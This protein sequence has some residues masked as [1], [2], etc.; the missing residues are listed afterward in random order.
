MI[1]TYLVLSRVTPTHRPGSKGYRKYYRHR[2]AKTGIPR[3]VQSTSTIHMMPFTKVS[4]S[5]SS[6]REKKED[7]NLESYVLHKYQLLPGTCTLFHLNLLINPTPSVLS[8]LLNSTLICNPHCL[9]SSLSRKNLQYSSFV[10]LCA[11]AC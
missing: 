7:K 1:L 4:L 10:T 3:S 11:S 2:R 9:Y 5:L 6:V 8:F